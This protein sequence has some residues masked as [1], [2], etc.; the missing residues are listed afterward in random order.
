MAWQSCSSIVF[1]P[2]P[3]QVTHFQLQQQREFEERAAA[4]AA[5][6]RDMMARRELSA[7]QYARQVGRQGSSQLLLFKIADISAEQYARQ[8]GARTGRL[9]VVRVHARERG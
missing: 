7:E 6:E 2:G 9:V 5:A 8:A 1:L 3:P 4:E